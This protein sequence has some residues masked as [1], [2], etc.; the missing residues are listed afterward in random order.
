[1]NHRIK[2]WGTLQ[3]RG[4]VFLWLLTQIDRNGCSL[5][6]CFVPEEKPAAWWERNFNSEVRRKEDL[7]FSRWKWQWKHQAGYDG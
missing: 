1:M 5:G 7:G 6:L 3:V 2:L 4:A